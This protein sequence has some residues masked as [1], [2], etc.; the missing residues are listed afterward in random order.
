[1]QPQCKLTCTEQWYRGIKSCQSALE[2]N[3]SEHVLVEV[4]DCGKANSVIICLICTLRLTER[5]PSIFAQQPVWHAKVYVRHVS[6][7]HDKKLHG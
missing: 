1:M 6:L 3:K 2:G 4:I 7:C 5:L